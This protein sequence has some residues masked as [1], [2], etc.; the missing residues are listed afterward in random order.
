MD[1]T[2]PG[3]PY[4]ASDMSPEALMRLLFTP[5]RTQPSPEVKQ[6]LDRAAT[7]VEV[8]D[9]NDTVHYV[10]GDGQRR[11]LLVHG[12]SG[13]AG[14]MAALAEA[15]VAA[16]F[17]VVAV[18]QPGHGQSAGEQSSVVHFAQA[19]QTANRRYGPFYAV[20]AHSLGAAATAYA[21]SRGLGCR[22]AV[23]FNPVGSYQSLW[24]RN[25]EV[26]QISPNLM[27]LTARRAEEWL[28]ISFDD[29]E[30]AALA[31]SMSCE[32]LVFHDEHD[33]ETPISD[34]QALVQSWP[35]AELVRVDK[36]GHTRILS[37]GEAIRRTVAFLTGLG[38]A[39]SS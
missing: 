11:I 4:G 26:L 23:F 6:I 7:E 14:H 39:R 38:A 8:V 24:R 32:L 10:W 2:E 36:L 19:I 3:G 9:G 21:L 31:K 37:D 27:A 30:P 33:R 28:G 29:L 1:T 22:G 18:D 13:N 34:S 15:L 16:G 17:Q 5:V 35:N 12:W 20:L 25:V